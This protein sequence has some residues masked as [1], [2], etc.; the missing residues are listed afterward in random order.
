MPKKYKADRAD[1]KGFIHGELIH[2]NGMTF[3]RENK[4]YARKIKVMS[5][6]IEEIR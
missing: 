1:G 3:I 2:E 5:Q 6:T 4:K